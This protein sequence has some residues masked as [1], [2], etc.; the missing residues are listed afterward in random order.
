M[1]FE[2]VSKLTT[3]LINEFSE[4]GVTFLKHFHLINRYLQFELFKKLGVSLQ[5]IQMYE[6]W[7]NIVSVETLYRLSKAF[8]WSI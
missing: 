4:V 1:I 7:N 5:S 2:R 3:L 6:Q 8:G